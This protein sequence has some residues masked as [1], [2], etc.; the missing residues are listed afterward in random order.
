M[1]LWAYWLTG[2]YIVWSE[3]GAP[4]ATPSNF[5]LS[6]TA[7]PCGDYRRLH[8]SSFFPS[9]TSPDYV[10]HHRPW[11][12]IPDSL[13]ARS[14]LPQSSPTPPLHLYP[15]LPLSTYPRLCPPSPRPPQLNPST[16][17]SAP[18]SLLYHRPPPH[19]L[20]APLPPPPPSPPPPPHCP[21][22]STASTAHRPLPVPSSINARR[23]P[24]PA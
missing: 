6:P 15:P 11:T 18:C 24:N 2:E 23:L 1:P 20:T 12:Q 16:Y 7:L 3:A 19:R 13:L 4:T 9:L 21:T 14:T 8:R 22:T 17:L 10:P 5:S